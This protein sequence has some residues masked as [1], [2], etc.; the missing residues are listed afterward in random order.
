MKKIRYF[1]EM[2]AL[3]FFLGISKLLGAQRASNFGAWIGRNIGARLAASRKAI[4]NIQMIYPDKSLADAT[5]I[6]TGMWENL[7]RVI[8]EYPHI[9][10]I[11]KNH[12]KIIGI[13]RVQEYFADKD[14][15]PPIFITGHFANWEVCPPACVIQTGIKV[16][17]IYRAPNNPFVDRLLNNKRSMKGT[18]SPISKSRSGTR[19]I[20]QTLKRG[21]SIGMLIDQKYNEGVVA[22]FMGN[23]AKTSDHFITMARKLKSPI[24]PFH[25]E[26]LDGINIQITVCDAIEIDGKSDADILS[27]THD[28]LESWI[29]KR[30]E[31]WLWLHR[32]WMNKAEIERYQNEQKD[33]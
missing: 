13:E 30:P 33:T 24:V 5:A 20:I 3:T 25:I 27:S 26:R 23:P 32:R 6:T 15:T 21:E 31:Q 19:Q 17:P 12:T 7:G 16:H 28:V 10:T 11:A 8:M 4:A 2:T 22:D 18:L 9:E 14:K 1:F 29:H